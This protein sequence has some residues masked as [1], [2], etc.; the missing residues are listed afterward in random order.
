MKGI[1]NAHEERIVEGS[2]VLTRPIPPEE[3]PP[4]KFYLMRHF[5]D[6][7]NPEEPLVHDITTSV[8]TNV[9]VRNG[10]AGDADV[11]FMPSI[12]EEV[13]DLGPIE[14][15][16]GFTFSIGLTISGGKVLHKYKR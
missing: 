6:Y 8:V 12:F 13:A 10:W 15:L 5:P 9:Q 1:C 14:A 16:D 11:R 4:V 2:L 7:E 3:A